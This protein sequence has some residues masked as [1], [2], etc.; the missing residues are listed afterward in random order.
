MFDFHMHTRVS[1]DG[2]DTAVNM[3]KAAQ[4]AGLCEICFTDHMDYD[5]L[6]PNH[7]LHFELAD[8]INEYDDLEV[9][10][11]TIRRGFEFG[12]LPDNR[13]QFLQDVSLRS[14]DFVIGSLHFVDGLD[15]YYPRYW[16]GKT[17][18]QAILRSFE[19]TLQCVKNHDGFDVLGHLTYLGKCD[20]NPEKKPILYRD[21]R[22]VADE[23]MKIL[24]DKGI[25][26][27]FNTSGLDRCGDYLPGVEY[28]R[29]FKELGGEIVTVGSDAHHADRVGQYCA[30]GCKIVQDIFG[31]VCTFDHR[32]PRFHTLKFL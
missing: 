22:E 4:N 29:R 24:V 8:Y 18:Y 6:D 21:Y 1:F 16:E 32:K 27:E 13:D 31:Y 26:M 30:E 7:K 25:G 15:V 23:I 2:R 19:D 12:M 11:L 3:A 28:L 20:A 5:P 17:P 14:W 9:P 10:G